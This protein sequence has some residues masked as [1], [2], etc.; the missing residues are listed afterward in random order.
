[1]LCS[2]FKGVLPSDLFD[3]YDCKGGFIKLEYDMLIAAEMSE[4]ILEQTERS[5]NE[6]SSR[7]AKRAVATRNQKREKMTSEAMDKWLKGD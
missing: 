7:R 3:K 4:R 2:T 5:N 1:M 6:S